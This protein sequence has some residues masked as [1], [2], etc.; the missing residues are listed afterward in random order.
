MISDLTTAGGSPEFPIVPQGTNLSLGI[1]EGCGSAAMFIQP[2]RSVLEFLDQRAPRPNYEG[3]EHLLA[4]LFE[5][6]QNEVKALNAACLF[7]KGL[8]KKGLSVSAACARALVVYARQGWKPKTFRETYDQ[9]ARAKDWVALVN[10]AKA[11]AAWKPENRGLSDSFLEFCAVKI[12]EYGRGDGEQ[13]A[14]IAIKRIWR[15]GRNEYGHEKTIPG[16]EK[17]WARRNPEVYPAGWHRT[18]I[19]RQIKARNKITDAAKK[20]LHEGTSA[21]KQHLPHNLRTRV[22]LRF[23]EQVTFDDVRMDFM[24]FDPETGAPCECWLLLARDTATTMVLGFVMHPALP[25][26]DGTVSHLGLKEMKQLAA[27]L[28]ERYPLPKDYVVHWVVER[29]TATLSE[30]TARALQEM[31]P[32][33]IQ[34]HFTSMVG[35]R[36][37]TGYTEKKKGNSKGKASHESL[38]RLGHTQASYIPGQIGAHYGIRPADLNAKIEECKATWEMRNHLPEH[39]RGQEKYELFTPAEAREHLTRIFLDQNFRYDHAIE[40]FTEVREWLDETAGQWKDRALW[41]GNTVTWRKRKERP[42]ER[43]A[44]LIAGHEWEH[45]SLDVIV[46]ILKHTQKS[47]PVGDSGEINLTVDGTLMIFAPAANATIPS[48]KTDVLTYFNADDPQ[49][50]HVTTGRG[51]IL[52][53]WYRRGRNTGKDEEAL[54]QAFRY[55]SHALATVQQR[56]E[57][58]AQPQRERSEAIRQHNAELERGNDFIE[59]AKPELPAGDSS[60]SSPIAHALATSV[61]AVKQRDQKQKTEEADYERMAREAI[62]NNHG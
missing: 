1:F 11:P 58:L 54:Q 56:A 6:G 34:V 19:Q 59:I 2:V 48:E 9:W 4:T 7:V 13:Q 55:T 62:R 57:Q 41:T 24:M 16:Y 3:E 35:G 52:G 49:F 46:A 10:I 43:A 42:V 25:R 47:R 39:L 51:K 33:R 45:V 26:E 36:S 44:R 17:H 32:S 38:N 53:T 15:T 29:G 8:V 14:L 12:A 22:H 28:L 61:P 5:D 27:W 21:A 40:G 18:N 37:A 31:L 30:G 50:L 60:L 23:M 20:M